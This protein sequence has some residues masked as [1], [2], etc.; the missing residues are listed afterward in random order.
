VA[1]VALA[2]AAAI[3]TSMV[4]TALLRREHLQLA[5]RRAQADWVLHSACQRAATRLAADPQYE[6]ETWTPAFADFDAR[7]KAEVEIRV[8]PTAE[9]STPRRIEVVVQYEV[10]G[11]LTQCRR[12]LAV[13]GSTE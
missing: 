11:K 9:T 7:A 4:K 3:S 1:L 12:T 6:G 8:T 13:E 2:V 10:Q 5:H